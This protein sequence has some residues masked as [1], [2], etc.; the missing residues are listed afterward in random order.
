M[1][2]IT[3][4][5]GTVVPSSWLND[6]NTGVY[7]ANSA[8]A[9]SP[10]RTLL[11]KLADVVSV[12]DS[13][14]TGDGVTNDFANVVLA[15]IAAASR[16]A[17]LVITNG[18][19]VMNTSYSFTA[20][21][22][23]LG[24]IFTGTGTVSFPQGFEASPYYCFDC[25][26]GYVKTEVLH[27]EWFGVR[28][29]TATPTSLSQDISSK[30]WNAWPAFIT[31]AG[32][33]TTQNYGNGAFL[34]ANKPFSNA[35]TWDWIAI[36]RALWAL[37]DINVTGI[38]GEVRLFAADYFLSRAI[39]YV[40]GM[41]STLRGAGRTKTLIQYANYAS[42]EVQTF[43]IS[44]GKSLFSGY[45][46]GPDPTYVADLCFRGPNS[47]SYGQ[48][49]R[50]LN[51]ALTNCNGV[52]FE[53]VWDTVADADIY[54]EDS[55]SD[56]WVRGCLFEYAVNQVYGFDTGSW[57]Q[58]ADSGFWQSPGLSMCGVN[59][60]GYAF[61]N[62]CTMVS[63][64]TPFIVG[65]GSS[66]S[67]VTLI[68]GG[69]GYR[70]T[71]NGKLITRRLDVPAG[72]TANVVT[73]TMPNFTALTTRMRYGGVLSTVGV[74]GLLRELTWYR[75]TTNPTAAVLTATAK[76]GNGAATPQIGESTITSA[77]GFTLQMTNAGAT[78]FS[79]DVS[80]LI[81][82]SDCILSGF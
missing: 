68:Q 30:A 78:T 17:T 14:A 29:S 67:G 66:F 63:L 46:I 24:G 51:I 42:H 3:Y 48:V 18:R 38:R 22:L 1:A 81:E 8:I 15:D 62:G 45:K 10:N 5:P 23:M 54:L 7:K 73:V 49:P 76:W 47:F 27:A 43:S 19:F 75:E 55:C 40:G 71:I 59:T 58:I 74:A 20:P 4:S 72:S 41:C 13:G 77:T 6:V 28:N 69:T 61:I 56:I 11:D 80:V 39:R 31:G 82:G 52:T 44:T 16:G 60:A 70:S 25:L 32:F 57:V 64:D 79:G 36:Q 21:V 37:G 26:V 53:N 9:A 35:D 50:G 65:T 33:G 2:S 12:K 34:A